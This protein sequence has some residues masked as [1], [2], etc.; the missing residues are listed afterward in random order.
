MKLS[1]LAIT[2]GLVTISLTACNGGDS[3]KEPDFTITAIDGYIVK[4]IVSA[5]CGDQYHNIYT[6]RTNEL[7]VASLFT[8]GASITSCR[9]QISADGDTYDRDRASVAW[10]HTMVSL[11][12]L[13]VIN[14]YTDIGATIF[15]NAPSLT[16]DETLQRV[17][18]LLTIPSELG[19]T[20]VNLFLDYGVNNSGSGLDT[21]T[22]AKVAV[23]A[24]STFAAIV[25]LK[26]SLPAQPSSANLLTLYKVVLPQV[27]AAV[28]AKIQEVGE[29]NLEKLVFSI[30]LALP[31]KISFLD[32]GELESSLTELSINI[33]TSEKPAF[34]HTGGEDTSQG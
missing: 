14:P 21:V 29:D 31:D 13:A 32:N 33:V 17:F 4:G 15:E 25:A 27:T 34:G 11:P 6:A 23:L 3:A 26:A 18:T 19:L 16:L 8:M 2:I 5:A 9:A 12:G 30:E 24:E 22:Q 10:L 1:K 7:G 20:D 28:H